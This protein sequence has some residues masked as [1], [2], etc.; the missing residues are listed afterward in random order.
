LRKFRPK[1][2]ENWFD[3]NKRIK[4]FL[5]DLLLKYV[6]PDYKIKE[7][8]IENE[9]VTEKESDVLLKSKTFE[10][11]VEKTNFKRSETDFIENAKLSTGKIE[12]EEETKKYDENTKIIELTKNVNEMKIDNKLLSE[13]LYNGYKAE[14]DFARLLVVTHGGVIMEL[15]NIIYR[16]KGIDKMAKNEAHNTGLTIIRIYCGVCGGKCKNEQNC[17]L[18]FDYILT[19][20]NK[21]CKHLNQ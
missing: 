7:D 3:V 13:I 8:T 21:H 2:G 16:F 6:N 12:T 5:D 14:T 9:K 18:E 17:K 15:N 19:N 11:G 4:K 20:D 1:E 10:L